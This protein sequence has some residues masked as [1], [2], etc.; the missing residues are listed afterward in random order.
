MA[1]RD[2][3]LGRDRKLQ[4]TVGAFHAKGASPIEAPHS[5]F[6]RFGGA[7]DAI[8]QGRQV[9]RAEGDPFG[10]TELAGDREARP[11]PLDPLIGATDERQIPAEHAERESL[12]GRGPDRP[13]DRQRL[14]GERH[15][16]SEPA[17]QHEDAG[18]VGQDTGPRRRRRVD[19]DESLRLGDGGGRRL[20]VPGLPEIPTLPFLERCRPRG[21]RRGID[22]SD[23]TAAELDRIAVRPDQDGRLSGA[24]EDRDVVPAQ[25][26]DVRR[27]RRV[28]RASVTDPLPEFERSPVEAMGLGESVAALGGLSGLDRRHQ[29]ASRVTRGIP[30]VGELG[31]RGRRASGGSTGDT[32]GGPRLECSGI[33]S[34]ESG[35]LAGEKIAMDDF[36]EEGV[37]EDE[38]WVARAAGGHQDSPVDHLAKGRANRSRRQLGDGRQEF[39]VD[40]R[41]GCRGDA[42]QLLPG[43]GAGSDTGQHHIAESRRELAIGRLPG[44]GQDLLR[45]EGVPAGPLHHP[46]DEGRFG[47]STELVGDEPRQVLPVEAGE[48]H[49]IDEVPTFEFGEIRAEGTPGIGLVGPDGRDHEHRLGAEVPDQEGEQ[50]PRRWI[51][52]LEV[53]DQQQDRGHA[54]QSLDD[55]EHELEESSLREA[56]LPAEFHRHRTC[57]ASAG[58]LRPAPDLGH[59]PRQ[60]RAV[61]TEQ[62]REHAGSIPRR[63]IRNASTNGAYGSPPV[64]SGR[65]PPRRTRAPEP[66]ARAATISTRRLL[67]IPASPA[68]TT[69]VDSPAVARRHASASRSSSTVRPMN[70]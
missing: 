40:P 59:Q 20:A 16:F 2:G 61:G 55:A 46:V 1:E 9:R 62:G 5:G 69:S 37:V 8:E 26:T 19:G 32:R 36:L 14:L 64:P 4:A 12:I 30:V 50:V 11:D 39:V 48:V 58:P 6:E 54:C 34:M 60:L 35:A 18:V 70:A 15:R 3:C 10:P 17:A 7:A 51:G 27:V 65:Q 47:R 29:R 13:G 31:D 22:Q 43:V 24:H 57:R 49:P 28:E 45:V 38:M 41:P 25:P 68:M 23:R 52:P 63:R 33:G 44:G 21:V 67:P 42:Q 66:D 56:V 53:L